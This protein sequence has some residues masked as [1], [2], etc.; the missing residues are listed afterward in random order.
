MATPGLIDRRSAVIQSSASQ[1]SG[2]DQI[3]CPDNGTHNACVDNVS[4]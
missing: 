4:F 1:N 2:S 3:F